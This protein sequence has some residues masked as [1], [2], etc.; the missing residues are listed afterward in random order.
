MAFEPSRPTSRGA[1]S[2][3][4]PRGR[5][6]ARYSGDLR[7]PPA[8]LCRSNRPPQRGVSFF[9]RCL[10]FFCFF[11]VLV[12]THFAQ[13]SLEGFR[14]NSPFQVVPEVH[15]HQIAVQIMP[16]WFATWNTGRFTLASWC[17]CWGI[18]GTSR[19]GSMGNSL[20]G[21]R[22]FER[23]DWPTV[24]ASCKTGCRSVKVAHGLREA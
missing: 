19:T 10:L 14:S 9:H 15:G 3:A 7:K 20:P 18:W 23:A 2:S 1:I 11:L 16:H 17:Q 5:G 8:D 13:V 4:P 6:S 21:H 24:F 12:D 22:C